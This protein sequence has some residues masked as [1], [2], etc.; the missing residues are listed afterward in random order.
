MQQKSKSTRTRRTYPRQRGPAIVM[1]VLF[2]LACAIVAAIVLLLFAL[3]TGWG[4]TPADMPHIAP[5]VVCLLPAVA[6]GY[7]ETMSVRCV[8]TGTVATQAEITYA[9]QHTLCAA[10]LR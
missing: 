5:Q 4:R 3:I 7:K 1:T 10:S 8:N 6:S 9:L 2:M